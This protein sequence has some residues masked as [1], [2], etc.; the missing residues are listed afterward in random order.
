MIPL[1]ENRPGYNY[2]LHE[3]IALTS[4]EFYVHINLFIVQYLQNR[5]GIKFCH[6][7]NLF[8]DLFKPQQESERIAVLKEKS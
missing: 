1:C 7:S 4:V 5:I 3:L 2:A 8:F 6:T